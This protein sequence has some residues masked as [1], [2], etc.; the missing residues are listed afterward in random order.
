MVAQPWRFF[1]EVDPDREYVVVS[2]FLQ[3]EAS[4]MRRAF[5]RDVK[6]I[7]GQLAS[8]A[9]LVGY[10]LRFKFWTRH[11]WTVSIWEDEGSI[12][13]FKETAPHRDVMTPQDWRLAEFGSVQW[14]LR[15]AEVPPSWEET[16]DRLGSRLAGP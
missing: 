14:P 6:R 8:S 12:T 7:E 9:G 3:L 11:Y 1:A 15:G 4:R 13:A 10:S 16:L 5:R 2:T